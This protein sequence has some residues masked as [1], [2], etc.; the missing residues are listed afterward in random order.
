MD[1]SGVK[2]SGVKVSLI[3]DKDAGDPLESTESDLIDI[4]YA[5]N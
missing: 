4:V 3:A 5:G 2:T 1:K